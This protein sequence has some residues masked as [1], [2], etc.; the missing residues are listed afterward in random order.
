MYRAMRPSCSPLG[1]TSVSV[2]FRPPVQLFLASSAFFVFVFL[3]STGFSVR[4]YVA[5]AQTHG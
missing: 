5:S 2:Y 3:H 4:H 1:C